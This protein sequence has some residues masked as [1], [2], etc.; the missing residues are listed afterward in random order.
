MWAQ[1][2]WAA[3]PVVLVLVWFL[4]LIGGRS[5]GGLIH[6]LLVAALAALL[7]NPVSGRSA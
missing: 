3:V 1:L 4:A 7:W 5:V 6:L 2:A